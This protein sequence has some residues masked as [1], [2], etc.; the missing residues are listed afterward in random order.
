MSTDLDAAVDALYAGEADEFVAAR[1]RL[2]RALTKAGD[3]QAAA[4]VKGLRRPSVAAAA[5]NRLARTDPDGIAELLDLGAQLAR[6][7]QDAV[8]GGGSKALRQLTTERRRLV[9]RLSSAAGRGLTASARDA[10][11]ATLEAAT[12]TPEVGELLRAGRLT[13]EA[14]SAGFGLDLAAL[15]TT[16][17]PRRP[18]KRAPHAPRSPR[19]TVAPDAPAPGKPVAPRGKHDKPRRTERAGSERVAEQAAEEARTKRA[20]ADADER[21]AVAAKAEVAARERALKD[22][23]KALAEAQRRAQRSELAAATA[24]HKVWELGERDR[25]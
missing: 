1:D 8:T 12:V 14:S 6:A 18:E 20:T 3:R 13:T 23:K 4:S 15:A 22:A 17:E 10:V 24:E 19:L 25:G 21:A 5:L 9:A 11:G 16:T 7:Q 2:A